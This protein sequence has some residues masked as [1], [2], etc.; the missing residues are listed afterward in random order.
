[1]CADKAMERLYPYTKIYNHLR[2]INIYLAGDFCIL[3]EWGLTIGLQHVYDQ[4]LLSLLISR[5]FPGI[6]ICIAYEHI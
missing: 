4:H 5:D 2:Q 6:Y 3:Y 1:M